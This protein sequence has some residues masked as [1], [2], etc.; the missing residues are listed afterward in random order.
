M[1]VVAVIYVQEKAD[2]LHVFC[3]FLCVLER[4]VS[5]VFWSNP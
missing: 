5:G 1:A 3:V 4:F 2:L